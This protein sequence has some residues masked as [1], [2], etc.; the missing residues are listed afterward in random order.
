MLFNSYAFIFLFLPLSLAVYFFLSRRR[1]VLA[2]RSWL[3]GTSLFFYA[4]WNPLYL[5]LILVSIMFNYAIGT[6]MGRMALGED[7][8][9]KRR[10]YV[11]I[12]GIAGNLGLLGYYK[13][14]DFFLSN[15]NW[16][17]SSQIPLLHI[18]L[19]LGI[20]F[21]TFTQIAY[22]VDVHRQVAKEYDLLN[23]ALFVTFFPHLIAGPIIHHKEMMPQF[24][25]LRNKVFH[26]GNFS[27]GLFLF[28]IGLFK[29][30]MIADT[31]AVWANNGFETTKVLTFTAAWATSLSYTLQ[32]YFD[33]SGYTDMALGSALM[34]NINLPINFNSPYQA[35]DIRDFWRRWHI[36]LSRYLRD[37]LYI[38]LGGNRHGDAK[39]AVNLMTTFLLGGIWHGASWTFLFWGFLHGTAMVVHRLWQKLQ[40]PLPRTLAWFLTLNFV[41]FAF[42]FFRARDWGQALKVVKGM[43]LMNGVTLAGWLQNYLG[44]N[45]TALGVDFGNP[46][47]PIQ[48]SDFTLVVIVVGFLV[49]L[50]HKNSMQMVNEFQPNWR[51]ALMTACFAFFSIINIYQ[52]QI[53]LYFNF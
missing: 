53:F 35:L 13:Y 47:R 18:I 17:V 39:T 14:T 38:P 2:A 9:Q 46:W 48:G 3:V 51:H 31:F 28:S 40:T 12:L 27:R 49:I 43:F 41:N 24:A 1:L 19:P 32:L 15:L 50:I 29:K 42:V 7:R 37:Y 45:L 33:F 11:L 25:T 34:F 30:V 16:A 10:K 4:W 26:W 8:L 23:Y 5:P 36:T 52:A 22:L 44:S 21:F 20:S 6:I